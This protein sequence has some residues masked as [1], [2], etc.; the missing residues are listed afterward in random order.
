[1]SS[2]GSGGFGVV[3]SLGPLVAV[4]LVLLTLIG[5]GAYFAFR[6]SLPDPGSAEYEQVTRA[7]YRGLA[8]L[9][10]GLLDDA[11]DQFA[12]A[13]EL[14]PEEPASWANLGLAR[15]RLGDADGAAPAIQRALELAPD[16]ADVLMLASRL[17]SARGQLD[18]SVLLLRRAVAADAADLRA[19]FALVEELDRAG[20]AE[21]GDEVPLLLDGL[22]DRV[23]ANL[24]VLVERTRMAARRADA[25]R[26]RDSVMRIDA[27]SAGW[28]DI[29]LEQLGGLRQAVASSQWPDAVRSAALLRNVLARVPAFGESL[30]QV[31]TPAELVGQPLTRFAALEQPVSTPSPPDAALTFAAE[32]LGAV[33]GVSAVLALY[34]PESGPILAAAGDTELR[35]MDGSASPLASWPIGSASRGALALDWNHD[36]RSDL[37]IVGPAG[38][39]LFLQAADGTF[40]D[41]TPGA[42]SAIPTDVAAAWAADVEMDGDLDLVLG[43]TAGPTAVLRNNGDGTWRPTSS[44]GAVSNARAFAWA[45]LDGDGDPDAAFLNANG[46]LAVLRNRQA[47][48]FD[49]EAVV[50]GLGSSA[51]VTVADL[52][53]DG[54]FEV[55]LL[56]RDGAVSGAIRGPDG[57]TVR[58]LAQWDA[59]GTLDV[60]RAGLMAGDL[61]NNGALDLVASAATNARAWL[62]RDMTFEELAVPLG[63]SVAGALDVTGDGTLDLFG[64]AGGQVMR[65][66][67]KGSRGYHWKAIRVQAQQN[68]GDQ[69]I[70]SFGVGGEIEVRSGLLWQ[71]QPIAGPVLHFGLGDARGIDVARVVWPNGIPQAEFE[72]ALD[73]PLVAEQRLKGSCPWVFANDGRE[74]RFVTDFL[75]RSPLGLRI[76]AQDTAGVVQTEDWVRI[77]G[78]QLAP[79]DGVYDVR[80][81]AELWETHFF[82]YVSLLVVDHAPG[83]EVF[84]DERFSAARPPALDLQAVRDLR[85]VSNARDDEHRDVTALVAARDGR[86]VAGFAKGAYQGIAREHYVEF[87][88]PAGVPA[89]PVLVAQGWVYPTD[90]SINMAIAQGAAVRPSGVSLEAEVDGRWR[91]LDPDIGFPAGKNKT[92]IVDLQAARRA[93]RLRL[94]TNLEIYW[95]RLAIAERVSER[96]R[97][98]R[99]A[100][101][102]AELRY[103]GFSTTTSPRGDQPETPA[104]APIAAV[105]QRWRDLE[106][107]YTRFG[108]VTPLVDRVDDRYVI[109]NAGDELQLRFPEQPARTGWSRDFV[110][111]GDGW[112]KDGDYNT[113]HSQTVLPLPDHATPAYGAGVV[114]AALE[115]DP[116]YKRNSD[117]WREFHTRYVTPGVFLQGI[118]PEGRRTADR[119]SAS[120]SGSSPRTQ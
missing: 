91:V 94:R 6:S 87:D 59:V 80:I 66:A 76:N 100:A 13:T 46:A 85:A 35:R 78:D 27:L 113:G 112:E 114:V 90:S 50:S 79:V 52:D 81:T 3:V 86:S 98:T 30:A 49:A 32:P 18:A 57:W 48:V 40:V 39:R 28:P 21:T 118:R 1:M 62:A 26:A 33:I 64:I 72:P 105:T 36:F 73:S 17:E 107:Y 67:G 31:R 45:D 69:R 20:V 84:V 54:A 111:I 70:N 29:A 120:P 88:L 42:T 14:V 95:D 34:G 115:D 22:A 89:A 116:V 44:F 9:D 75:W 51:A 4:A 24:A 119:L 56:G 10:V 61:D 104:Y 15:L 92:M 55:L 97:T 74:M 106:G 103:R 93:V 65:W 41:Q 12:R 47:G 25:T 101:S 53:A 99:L 102:S 68:A 117:D 23:P 63:G 110:L 2:K 7:F 82:D 38:L 43:V 5:A 58:G 83:T 108:D 37:A 77:G 8:A 16:R 11:R 60:G 109:M 96:P 71:K 19:R